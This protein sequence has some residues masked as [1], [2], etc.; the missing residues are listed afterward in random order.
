MNDENVNIANTINYHNGCNTYTTLASVTS[1]LENIF[2]KKD[3]KKF[4]KNKLF[5]E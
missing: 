5:L 2:E 1:R 3:K 4:Q